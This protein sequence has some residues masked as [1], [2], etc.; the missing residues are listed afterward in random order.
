MNSETR[1]KE[2]HDQWQEARQRGQELTATELCH[3]CP[4]L[5]DVVEER[6]KSWQADREPAG[7]LQPQK[8]GILSAAANQATLG[9]DSPKTSIGN[10]DNKVA[11]TSPAVLTANEIAI[12]LKPGG[13]PISGYRLVSRLGAGAS[14]EVWKALGPGNFPLAMK[15]IRLGDAAEALETRSLEFMKE[16]RHAHLLALSGTWQSHGMLV[17]AMELGDRTLL[18]RLDEAIHQGLEGI[19]YAELIGYMQDAAEGIDFLN[20]SCHNFMGKTGVSIQHR[21]IKPQNLLLVGRTV[22][23]ADFGLAKLLDQSVISNT[24]GLTVAY[25]APE[26]FEGKTFNRSDQYSLAVT[27]CQLRGGRLPFTG[28]HAQIM[29]GHLLQ[30]PDLSMIPED[31]RVVVG[32]ALAK[33]PEERW[34]NCRT[35]IR[36]LEK[37]AS[38]LPKRVAPIIAPP[39]LRRPVRILAVALLGV[40][41]GAALAYVVKGCFD[42]P[43]VTTTSITGPK[44]PTKPMPTQPVPDP[45]VV[46]RKK[47]ETKIEEGMAA[48]SQKEWD[49]AAVCFEEALRID[50]QCGTAYLGRGLVSLNKEHFREA[51]KDFEKADGL[52]TKTEPV[53][54][55]EALTK[56][57][58]T[59]YYQQE[60][61][62]TLADCTRALTF[63]PEA[64]LAHAYLGGALAEKDDDEQAA[65]HIGQALAIDPTLAIGLVMRGWVQFKRGETQQAFSDF[66]KALQLKENLADAFLMRGRAYRRLDQP[67]RALKDLN[68]ALRLNPRL[69]EAL[70]N[71]ALV[72]RTN[73]EMEKAL[74]DADEAIRLSVESPLGYATRGVILQSL[75]KTAAAQI[76]FTEALCRVDAKDAGS[77]HKRAAIY[78]LQKDYARAIADDSQAIQLNGKFP[79]AY[80]SRGNAWFE[81]G[82]FT[83]AIGDYTSAIHYQPNSAEYFVNRADAFMEEKDFD[84]AIFD[85]LEAIKL[86]LKSPKNYSKKGNAYFMKTEYVKAAEAFTD[87][88]VLDRKNAEYPARRGLAYAKLADAEPAPAAKNAALEKAIRDFSLAIELNDKNGEYYRFR[89]D[90]H[91][92]RADKDYQG[93]YE[94]ALGDYTKAIE[95]NSDD[96]SAYDHRGTVHFTTRHFDSAINDYTEAIKRNPKNADY[97]ANRAEAYAEKKM[98]PEAIQNYSEAI[99]RQPNHADHFQHRGEALEKM[100]EKTK[101]KQ[102]FEKARQLKKAGPEA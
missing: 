62:Q 84:R 17:V 10:D 82:N 28:I 97:W 20:E 64:P 50:D 40:A 55:A 48:I 39:P 9:S 44:I 46:N 69:V 71:R 102:D 42:H 70:A 86:G 98:Y 53:Y 80:N 49:V 37:V 38:S 26:F 56:R 72:Y 8:T 32:K 87:A 90:A 11:P 57:A 78:Y 89:G 95:L 36:E 25:A 30:K 100:G 14:G 58:I 66:S 81:S 73:N 5:I 45:V 63:I 93:E 7:T 24:G 21:D 83:R 19:P 74:S 79:A 23:V 16:I 59:Y 75:G 41:G 51:L 33:R 35:F 13:E 65:M 68:E 94:K 4:E 99:Q 43:G 31:E 91:Y 12:M 101:A 15:F 52:G 92:N 88:F 27:Y 29:A 77:Y 61:D 67:E 60:F 22:K 1:L 34:P 6:L 85:Y 96:A 47:A 54:Y 18:Q 2:I 3:K 76:D